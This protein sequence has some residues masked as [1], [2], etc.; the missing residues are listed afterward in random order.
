LALIELAS[1]AAF[2]SRIVLESSYAVR[3]PCVASGEDRRRR[4]VGFEL[5]TGPIRRSSV[6][7]TAAFVEQSP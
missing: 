5:A 2:A 6:R 7:A 1:L 4:S 3:L